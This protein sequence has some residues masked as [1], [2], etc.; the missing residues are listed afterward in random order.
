LA[1]QRLPAFLE[2]EISPS[3]S[4]RVP[5]QLQKL[6]VEMA[7]SN[8]T[9]GEERIADELL[10]KIG[11]RISPGTVRRYMPK[12]PQ[13]PADPKQHWMTFV[14]SRQRHHCV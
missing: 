12:T 2:T 6:I 1:S 7:T 10:L 14:K 4:T 13:R 5:V 9:W 3:R 11:I 8:L